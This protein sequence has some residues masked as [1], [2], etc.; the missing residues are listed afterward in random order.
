MIG[1]PSLDIDITGPSGLTAQPSAG[2]AIVGTPRLA[3]P[4]SPFTTSKS[5]SLSASLLESTR[6]D[7]VPPE[8]RG[9]GWSL[10]LDFDPDF[11]FDSSD[12]E[13]DVKDAQPGVVGDPSTPRLRA[14]VRAWLPRV[15]EMF[16]S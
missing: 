14:S 1:R 4:S 9:L 7:A 6:H 8:A 16:I 15:P 5:K 3:Q 2:A 11:D 12:L 10:G 13:N